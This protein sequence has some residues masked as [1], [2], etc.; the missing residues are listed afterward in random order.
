MMSEASAT[1]RPDGSNG[2]GRAR[3]GVMLSGSGRTLMNLL[4]VI[5]RGA[6]DA[7]VVLVIAS[8]ACL[9]EERARERGLTTV[10]EPGKIGAGRLEA[11]LSSHGVTLVA[12]AGYLKL[13]DVP[14]P[15][16][17]R[18]VNIHPALLP[19][20]GGP[21]MYGERVHAAVLAAGERESGCTVHLCDGGFDTGPIVLQRS[22][23]VL[24]GDTPQT[25]AARV[26]EQECIAYP[27]A[28]QLLIERGVPLDS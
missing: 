23:P 7:D 2:H 3:L 22:C 28:L 6:L 8:R 11:L 15:F 9:G 26:F 19:K 21:G 25:L 27:K 5:E 18:V 13:V 20:F 1:T 16:A 12:L 4:D 14:E 24:T 10:I 17:G